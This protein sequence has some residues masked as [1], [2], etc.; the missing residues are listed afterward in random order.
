MKISTDLGI[1]LYD[2][3]DVEVRQITQEFDKFIDF[4]DSDGP[5]NNI[6][7]MEHLSLK[8]YKKIKQWLKETFNVKI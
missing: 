6:L 7:F 2:L 3:T 8:D 1:Y 5:D 4:S